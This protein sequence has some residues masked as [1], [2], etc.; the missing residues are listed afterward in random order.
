[1]ERKKEQFRAVLQR[2]LPP[3]FIEIVVDLL[4]RN[5]VRFR[6]VKPRKTKLGDFRASSK[7]ECPQITINGDLNPY[8][9]LITTLHEFAHLHTFLEFGQHVAPHGQEWKQHYRMLIRPLTTSPHLPKDIRNALITSLSRTKASSCTDQQL[10]RVLLAYN[11]SEE[12]LIPL[13]RLEKNSIFALNGKRFKRGRLRRTRYLCVDLD[14]G[15]EYLVN[16]LALV[17]LI[18]HGK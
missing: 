2:Y 5:N 16:T 10:H 9:F 1:M 13:E 6:V 11:T 15:R 7:M 12:T 4:V 14:N 17:E 18:E 8:S 3:A